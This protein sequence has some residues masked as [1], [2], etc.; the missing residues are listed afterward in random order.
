[1]PLKSKSRV[2]YDKVETLYSK[3]YN[4]GV[5]WNSRWERDDR[6]G[7]A[8]GSDGLS[9]INSLCKYSNLASDDT[10]V[11]KYDLIANDAMLRLVEPV[12]RGYIEI[13]DVLGGKISVAPYRKS[14][15]SKSRLSKI[16]SPYVG[17]DFLNM[18]PYDYKTHVDTNDELSY[19]RAF[20]ILAIKNYN[21]DVEKARAY[22][23]DT[24]FSSWRYRR[25]TQASTRKGVRNKYEYILHPDLT[26]SK[27]ENWMQY[28]REIY[29]TA[30]YAGRVVAQASASSTWLGI[31]NISLMRSVVFGL[32][33]PV[34]YL[35]RN[36]RNGTY[37]YEGKG[38]TLITKDDK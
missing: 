18:A 19:E 31:H 13:I 14:V 10:H 25:I 17:I 6:V 20:Y 11:R 24:I 29:R 34:F 35:W 27:I 30:G 16:Y 7:K 21:G 32:A 28:G 1:M 37:L 23:K 8:L 36:L 3:L 26:H 22:V 5:P 12:L 33:S 38:V 2:W 15:P 4:N 9:I